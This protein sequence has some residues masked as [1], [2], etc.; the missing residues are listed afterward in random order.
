MIILDTDVIS[1]P[2]KLN[3]NTAVKSWL[4]KQVI[5]TLHLTT[6]SLSE[7]LIGIEILPAGKRKE[8]LSSELNTLLVRLFGSRI[9]SFDHEAALKYAPLISYA[10]ARGQPI[11]MADGQIAAIA[12]VNGFIVATRDTTSFIAAGVPVINPW[13]D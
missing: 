3:G 6:I 8:S 4:D 5:E 9:L 11:S 7:L 12:Q 2:M 13:E 1:E 10:R